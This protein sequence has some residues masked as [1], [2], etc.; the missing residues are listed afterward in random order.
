VIR[1]AKPESKTASTWLLTLLERRPRKGSAVALANKMAR[2]LWAK[3]A[4]YSAHARI[5]I[6]LGEMTRKLSDT[7]SQ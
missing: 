7:A 5:R 4:F 2:I 1:H 6:S 3:L